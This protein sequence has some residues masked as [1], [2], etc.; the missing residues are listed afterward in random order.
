MTDE[1]FVEASLYLD[2]RLGSGLDVMQFSHRTSQILMTVVPWCHGQVF[3][4][5]PPGH[6]FNPWKPSLDPAITGALCTRYDV[7]FLSII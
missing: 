4:C 3:T 1:F 6:G 7:F 5:Y 2:H